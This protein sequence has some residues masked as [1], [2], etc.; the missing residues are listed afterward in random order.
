[1]SASQ[2]GDSVTELEVFLPSV[3]KESPVR[4]YLVGVYPTCALYTSTPYPTSGL[5]T[6][7]LEQLECSSQSR[8][9]T[10]EE[11]QRTVQTI[12]T[13]CL[14]QVEEHLSKWSESS[15]P[16]LSKTAIHPFGDQYPL[17]KMAGAAPASAASTPAV[18]LPI[19]L[20]VGQEADK[21]ISLVPYS[22][23][24]GELGSDPNRHVCEFLLQ[25]NANNARTDAHWHSKFP[26]TFEDHAKLW[27]YRQ[28]LGSF[29]NW[30]SLRDAFVAYFCPIGYEDQLT[31]QLADITMAP[32]EAI[33]SYY[34]RMEDIIL[35]L[36]AN[37]GFNDRHIKIYLLED[38]YPNN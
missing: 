19:T 14:K 8:E 16:L 10:L 30:D 35:R 21:P 36:L 12:V 3:N 9:D 25:C 6:L 18:Q 38:W 27:F 13:A 17:G 32:G 5:P 34:G 28:P 26:T 37:Y 24:Y 33:D 7:D 23:F 31:E 29:S 15:S 4:E 1:M 2:D 22:K 20:R 11:C